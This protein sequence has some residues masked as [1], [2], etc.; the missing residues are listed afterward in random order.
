MS[1][2]LIKKKIK[3]TEKLLAISEYG[4]KWT[5]K[6]ESTIFYIVAV[7]RISSLTFH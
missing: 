1:L 7:A 2:L 4:S 3:V 6:S 5:W